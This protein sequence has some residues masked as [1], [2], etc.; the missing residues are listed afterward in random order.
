MSFEIVVPRHA[1]LIKRGSAIVAHNNM[2]D[3]EGN[4]YNACNLH[5]YVERIRNATD[6]ARSNY[7]TIARERYLETDYIRIGRVYTVNTEHK[8]WIE[9]PND[10]DD[11]KTVCA[12]LFDDTTKITQTNFAK[13]CQN[14]QFTK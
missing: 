7:P 4:I 13:E 1:S 9:C 10:D 11:F 5:S 8:I 14:L 2:I 12:W 3:F 6:R